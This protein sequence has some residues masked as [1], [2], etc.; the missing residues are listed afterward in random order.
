VNSKVTSHLEKFIAI[1]LLGTLFLPQFA[2]SANH[3]HLEGRTLVL[4]K[5]AGWNV[6]EV[7]PE[8]V[9]TAIR[10]KDGRLLRYGNTKAGF[11]GFLEEESENGLV[12]A[13]H[14][15]AEI[16]VLLGNKSGT[17]SIAEGK[18]VLYASIELHQKG[19]LALLKVVLQNTSAEIWGAEYRVLQYGAMGMSFEKVAEQ[20]SIEASRFSFLKALICNASLN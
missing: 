15:Q 1:A 7:Y 19:S 14:A 2:F 5:H 13:K 3:P 10:L 17:L 20:S 8:G 18:R 11:L 4:L 6:Y 9:N 16:E 12:R